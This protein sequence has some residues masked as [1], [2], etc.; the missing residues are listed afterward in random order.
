MR[1][2]A[3]LYH[4]GQTAQ[5]WPE[6][7]ATATII[8]VPDVAQQASRQGSPLTVPEGLARRDL[9]EDAF[10]VALPA[11]HPL[12]SRD[13][14]TITELADEDWV[15]WSAGQ[16]CHDWLVRT[17]RAHGAGPRIRHTASEH[18][19][20]LALVAAGLGTTVIPRLGRE[21]APAPVRFVPV[22]PPPVR[23]VYALWRASS[24]PRPAITTALDA[25]EQS[26]PPTA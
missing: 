16:I 6:S 2:N 15:S 10:D 13:S 22:D 7:R 9:L 11:G 20:Q 23:S 17:L 4:N 25:L 3:F 12:A 26:C 8:G 5:V 21:P 14:V 18:S 24:G 1:A 19:T